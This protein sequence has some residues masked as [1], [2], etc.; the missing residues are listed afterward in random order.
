MNVTMLETKTRCLLRV[1]TSI[2]I[3]VGRFVKN[4]LRRPAAVGWKA[5]W[6][7]KYT[8]NIM[9]TLAQK[10]INAKPREVQ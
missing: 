4:T 8:Q 3:R 1:S 5:E 9:Y 10:E 7:Q 2:K 6:I